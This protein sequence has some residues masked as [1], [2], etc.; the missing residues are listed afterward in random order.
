MR[1]CPWA[2]ADVTQ[3]CGYPLTLLHLVSLPAMCVGNAQ[4]MS[5]A[6]VMES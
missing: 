5:K 4:P 3:S 2:S 6:S 1:W